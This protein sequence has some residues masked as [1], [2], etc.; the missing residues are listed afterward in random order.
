MGKAA[1]MHKI[2]TSS[3][4]HGL[5]SSVFHLCQSSTCHSYKEGIPIHV[6]HYDFS[7]WPVHD[8]LL[9]SSTQSKWPAH[10]LHLILFH[11]SVDLEAHKTVK[12]MH[13]CHIGS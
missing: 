13:P 7:Q 1:V 12:K 3:L 8:D 11:P 9:L 2:S 6:G 5:V 10:E 4:R